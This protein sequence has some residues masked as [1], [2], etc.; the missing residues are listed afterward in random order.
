MRTL[1][2]LLLVSF[3]VPA[4]AQTG[5]RPRPPGTLPL[6]EVPPPPP[7]PESSPAEANAITPD[8][9]TRTEGNQTIQEYRHKGKLYMVRVTPSHGRPYVLVDQ[10]GDGHFTRQD[11]PLDTGLRVP[12]WVILEF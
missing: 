7:I 2:A 11:N 5:A 9:S 12:Q 8:V 10:R 4:A 3:L 6:E 1:L